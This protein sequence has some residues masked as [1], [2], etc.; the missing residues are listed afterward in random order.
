MSEHEYE[1]LRRKGIDPE[2]Y[3]ISGSMKQYRID[4]KRFIER[5]EKKF[6]ALKRTASG[7]K[8]LRRAGLL[9]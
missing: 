7:R 2:F 4:M 5:V 6:Q 8:K 9:D 1:T 3:A